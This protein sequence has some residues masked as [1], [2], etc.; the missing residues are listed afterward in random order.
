M[1]KA[2]YTEIL[3]LVFELYYEKFKPSFP[4]RTSFKPTLTLVDC[5]EPD[6]PESEV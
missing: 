5:G 4:N 2:Y 3:K 1:D 6:K